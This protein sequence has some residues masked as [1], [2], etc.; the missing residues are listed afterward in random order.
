MRGRIP[1]HVENEIKS[2]KDC[3][4]KIVPEIITEVEESSEHDLVET[5]TFRNFESK[6]MENTDLVYVVVFYQKGCEAC[7]LYMPQVGKY[8]ETLKND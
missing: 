4:A 3:E 2:P 5:L 6:I 7:K 8:A 1:Q